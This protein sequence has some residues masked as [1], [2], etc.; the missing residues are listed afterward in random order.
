MHTR[1][2]WLA[3][4]VFSWMPSV[5]SIT[6]NPGF[7]ADPYMSA[8]EAGGQFGLF[9]MPLGNGLNAP[10]SNQDIARV[11][12][13]LLADPAE[14]IGSSYR[15]TGPELLSPQDI[16][17]VFAEV[18]GRRV[19]YV[20]VPF[21]MLAKSAASA[22]Y[23]PYEIAQMRTYFEEYKRDTFAIGAPNNVVKQLTGRDP[24][25]F[26]QTTRHYADAS[27]TTQRTPSAMTRA[28]AGLVRM[29]AQPA[30]RHSR[31]AAIHE[32]EHVAGRRLAIDTE[33]WRDTHAP[34][35][36]LADGVEQH[37]AA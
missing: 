10:P 24:E 32:P 34:A 5:G 4:T 22:G 3:D 35:L 8:L 23:R 1:R 6:V 11:I 9:T 16:A 17:G 21:W 31:Y 15:P 36:A 14:H 29:T 18:L 7:F 12:A 27:R 28:L 13:A 2:T 19:R 33:Q 26:V 20:D 25:G 30:P 37:L